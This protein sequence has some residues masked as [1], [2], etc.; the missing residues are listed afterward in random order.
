MCPHL[1][2]ESCFW[3]DVAIGTPFFNTQGSY[4]QWG[5]TLVTA[6][7]GPHPAS[8]ARAAQP[9]PDPWPGLRPVCG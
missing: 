1:G 8:G 7:A 6:A 5:Q 3:L 4:R 2:I 9:L